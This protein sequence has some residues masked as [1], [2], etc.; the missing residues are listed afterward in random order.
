L[1]NPRTRT[2][3]IIPD[4]EGDYQI[5]DAVANAT[6]TVTGAKFIGV[7]A[8]AQCHGPSPIANVGL[9]DLVT[10]WSQTGHATFF[11]RAIDGLVSD[12]YNENCLSCHTVGYNKAPTARNDG[13]DDIATD[14]NWRFP[15]PLQIGNFASMF[16]PLQAKGNIQCENCHGPGSQHPGAKSESLNVAVCATCHQDGHYH[17]R[18]EQWE[19]SGHNEG[20][21]EV[22]KTRGTN[23][24]CAHCHAPMGHIDRTKGISPVR[25]GSGPLTCSVCHDPHNTKQFPEEAKQ[26]RIYD[27]V[28][29]DDSVAAPITLTGQGTSASCMFCHNARRSAPPTYASVTT[30]PHEGTQA[31]VLLGIRASTK[32][33]TV[34]AG[35][36][37]LLAEV[38][39]ENSAHQGVAKCIDCH[40]YPNPGIGQPGHNLMGDHTFSMK[41]LDTGEDN[42]PSCNQCHQGTKPVDKLDFVSIGAGDYD[43]NGTVDGVQTEVD[44]LLAILKAKMTSSGLTFTASDGVNTGSYSTNPVVRAVQR[45]AAWNRWLIVRDQSKGVH[46]TAFTVRLLQWTYTVLSTNAPDT[47]TGELGNSFIQDYPNAKLR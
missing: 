2:P 21:D 40:M 42:L 3:S 10:P 23:A 11:Q 39:L 7:S 14:L 15:N 5:R 6:I 18:V 24:S 34:V 20:Y 38:T 9:R 13:F 44:G 25:T 32:V 8:C 12:H 41:N 33:Q 4:V 28:V 35:V 46:N 27:T 19:R 1:E 36:T 37:N 43:G 17:T 16:A 29:L 31:D 22:S 26:L 47:V 45:N 30:V